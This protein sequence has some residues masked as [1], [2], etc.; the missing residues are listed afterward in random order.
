VKY[1][2]HMPNANAGAVGQPGVNTSTPPDTRALQNLASTALQVSAALLDAERKEKTALGTVALQRAMQEAQF[3]AAQV[4]P[5]DAEKTYANLREES[6]EKVL[7]QFGDDS[8]VASAIDQNYQRMD[9]AIGHKVRVDAWQRQQHATVAAIETADGEIRRAAGFVGG[10]SEATLLKE[11]VAELWES[12]ALAPQVRQRKI[13][14]SW[15]SIDRSW[16]EI[17]IERDPR[18]AETALQNPDEFPHLPAPDRV[19]YKRFVETRI[20]QRG[21]MSSAELSSAIRTDLDTVLATGERN[22]DST[23]V[24]ETAMMRGAWS[25]SE[26][27]E[28]TLNVELMLGNGLGHPGAAGRD[29]DRLPAQA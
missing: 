16:L 15:A 29:A 20:E 21:R 4:N 27:D 10:A 6:R 7:G 2:L 1:D 3:Q 14:E 24:L 8:E 23:R 22:P 18:A 9:A 5:A 28:H 11:Q 25:G 26:S 17:L 19:R 12:D 13:A